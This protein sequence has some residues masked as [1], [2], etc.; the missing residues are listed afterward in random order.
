[1]PTTSNTV[2]VLFKPTV[3]PSVSVTPLVVDDCDGMESTFTAT[4][5]NGGT[6]PVYHWQ[7]NGI[8]AGTNNSVFTSSTLVNNDMWLF[9]N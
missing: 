1:V 5:V 2:N 7:V 6:N 8:N 4:P 3:T 9:V